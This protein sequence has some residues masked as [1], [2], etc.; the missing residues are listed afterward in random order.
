[1]WR[2]TVLQKNYAR[3]QRGLRKD[4]AD[5]LPELLA[6]APHKREA[7][8]ALT[9]FETWDRLRSMQ[10]LTR[11]T[12]IEVIYE[13]LCLLFAVDQAAPGDSATREG[14]VRT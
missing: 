7:V 9:S 3:N 10:G 2:S 13:M 1:M 8:E 4:L 14:D 6:L 12:S 11:K 5:W